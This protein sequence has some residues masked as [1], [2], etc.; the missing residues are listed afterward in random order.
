MLKPP[1]HV[2]RCRR[3]RLPL[4]IADIAYCEFDDCPLRHRRYLLGAL[5]I[6]M[7]ALSVGLMCAAYIISSQPS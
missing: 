4:D 3:C 6:A 1:P 5:M 2:N 7:M